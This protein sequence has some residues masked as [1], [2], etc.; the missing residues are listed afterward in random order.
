MGEIEYVFYT[1]RTPQFGQ[2]TFQALSGHALLVVTILN[3]QTQ[4]FSDQCR[5][6]PLGQGCG[7]HKAF[8]ILFLVVQLRQ[9]H[10][11]LVGAV[12]TTFLSNSRVVFEIWK[13]MNIWEYD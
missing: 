7:K 2:S 12:S 6:E 1:Y 13:T 3:A 5:Q 10:N 4:T 8:L 11:L 9:E